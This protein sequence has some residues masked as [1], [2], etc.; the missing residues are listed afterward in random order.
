MKKQEISTTRVVERERTINKV[1]KAMQPIKACV[2][3]VKNVRFLNGKEI[4]VDGL[5]LSFTN[6]CLCENWL[7]LSAWQMAAG[8]EVIIDPRYSSVKT[9]S[10]AT[11]EEIVAAQNFEEAFYAAAE[12]IS[13]LHDSFYGQMTKASAADEVPLIG[14]M[15]DLQDA[16]FY[17]CNDVSD[18]SE[19]AVCNQ[20]IGELGYP[21]WADIVG[22]DTAVD[23]ERYFV[24]KYYPLLHSRK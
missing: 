19:E 24:K 5:K 17:A 16:L 6:E 7:A 14:V 22:T 15:F 3:N 1:K 21:W 2:N 12:R 4:I 23:L 9:L 18:A 10:E 20:M 13:V 8:T 11:E